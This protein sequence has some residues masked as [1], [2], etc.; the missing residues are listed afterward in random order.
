LSL[1]SRIAN[2][3]LN[4]K[5]SARYFYYLRTRCNEL[6]YVDHTGMVGKRYANDNYPELLSRY[7]SCIAAAT[8][9]PVIKYF[10]ITAAGC[11]TFMEVTERN[12]AANLGYQDGKTAIFINEQNY[13]D[14][15]EEYLNDPDNP[16]WEKIAM[17]G[18]K[19]TM[20]EKNNDKA[21]ES[22]VELMK[23]LL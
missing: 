4:P 16:E 15:F 19:Y 8:F 17:A 12:K 11:L 2:K 7:R 9:F 6:P 20:E 13:K 21:V 1:K 5:Q 22:L 10:E 14:K 23:S 18:R 3:I